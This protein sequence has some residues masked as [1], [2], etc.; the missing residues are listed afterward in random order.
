[1]GHGLHFAWIDDRQTS[2]NSR[3]PMVLADIAFTFNELL[4]LAFLLQPSA[5]CRHLCGSA[6]ELLPEHQHDWARI[7]RIVFQP[8]YCYQ[9]PLSNII[10]PLCYQNDRGSSRSLI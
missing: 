2:F 9:Y 3:P 8:F 6:V 5:V 10:S 7:A 1:M 4:L